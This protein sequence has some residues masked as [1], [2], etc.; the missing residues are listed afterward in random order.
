MPRPSAAGGPCRH[1]V[2]VVA[3]LLVFVLAG[4]TASFDAQTSKPYNPAQGV[5]VDAG[6]NGELKLRN[7]VAVAEEPGRATLVGTVVN[8]GSA[9]VLNGVDVAGGSA[10][11]TPNNPS[12]APGVTQIGYGEDDVV[13]VVLDSPRI[14]PGH[15]IALTFRFGTAA[16]V[17][18]DTQVVLNRGAFADV[19]VPA[20]SAA[21][22]HRPAPGA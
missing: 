20:A 10:E 6:E 3:A 1:A 9:D 17:T 11:L 4:C 21:P 14:E 19:E 8:A 13:T 7:I 22:A 12:L 5:N 16:P 15:T 18:I 2:V